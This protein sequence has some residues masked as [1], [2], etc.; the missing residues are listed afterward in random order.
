MKHAMLIAVLAAASMHVNAK[1]GNDPFAVCKS[2]FER[3]CKSVP[4]G[5]GRQVKCMMDNQASLSPACGQ[6]VQKK[7]EHEQKHQ[8]QKTRHEQKPQTQKTAHEQKPQTKTKY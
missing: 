1:D 2:D 5:D 4:A 6:V 7:R 8:A 3:L